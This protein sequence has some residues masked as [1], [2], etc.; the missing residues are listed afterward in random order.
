M[1]MTGFEIALAWLADLIFGDP[2][3]V[4]H[5]V[6][7]FGLLTK[8]G[9]KLAR[10]GADSNRGLLF[11][12]ALVAA[13]ITVGTWGGTWLLVTSVRRV[14]PLAAALVTVYLAYSALALRAL[15]EAACEVIGFVRS[16]RLEDARASLA[17]IVG[18]DT[19]DLEEAEILRAV[20]ETVAENSSDGVIAPLLYLTIGG[21]PAA[22][23]YKSIN[24]MDSMIGYRN[25]RY[26]YFGRAAARLDDVVNFIPSRLT[27]ALAILASLVLGLEWRNALRV[28]LR[29]ANSQPSPN[30][31]FPEAAFAGAL[32]IQ[33]GGRSSYAGQ[34]SWKAHLG[35]PGRRLAPD[36]FPQVRRLL[37]GACGLGLLLSLAV[38]AMW[39]RLV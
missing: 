16:G 3:W 39:G 8:T 25:E 11:A 29:D 7:F 15:D 19:Q 23:A 14:S 1:P 12:G 9:E 18:R 28:I 6:R 4:P 22:L 5:P 24:T 38:S 36:L 20:I 30:S 13:G 31:G 21:V 37:Y 34:E 33:L 17:G 10:V 2:P 32:G 26:Q 27:A 35:N